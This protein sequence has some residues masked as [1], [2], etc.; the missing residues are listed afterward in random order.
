M[1]STTSNSTLVDYASA[2]AEVAKL[3]TYQLPAAPGYEITVTLVSPY[4]V[5]P[6]S[7]PCLPSTDDWMWG[8]GNVSNLSFGEWL[9]RYVNPG[10]GD[11][12]RFL[13]LNLYSQYLY[14]V[15]LDAL[16]WR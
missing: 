8:P 15:M 5:E 11:L 9:Q 2:R 10:L 7:P 3:R 1:P 14:S 6:P 12:K 13:N 4:N 16:E